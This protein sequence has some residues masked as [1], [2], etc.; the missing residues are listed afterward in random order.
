[1]RLLLAFLLLSLPCHRIL[2]QSVSLATA[3][4][5][6]V[7]GAIT[8]F[9]SVIRNDSL[10]LVCFWATSSDPSLDELNAINS[11]YDKWKKAV[12]FRMLAVSI[13]EGTEA[14]KVR[15]VANMNGWKFDVFTDIEGDLRTAVHSTSIPQAV[16]IKSGKVVYLQSGFDPGSENYLLEKLRSIAA[17]KS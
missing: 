12:N 14:N 3:R 17:G 11:N 10:V 16:I 8:S 13:D 7:H 4:L 6:P 2:A 5:K 1:M 9:G 15:P